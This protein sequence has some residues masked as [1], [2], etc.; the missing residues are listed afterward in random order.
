MQFFFTTYQFSAIKK[1][2]ATVF[3]SLFL[4]CQPAV[5]EKTQDSS[6]NIIETT[7]EHQ[8]ATDLITPYKD[9]LE[10]E[11]NEVL[12]ISAEEFPKEKGKPETKL[13]NLVADLSIEIAQKTYNSNIDFCLLNFGGLRTSLPKGEITRGKIFELMPF[14]NELV[15]V[16]ISKEQFE[17]LIGYLYTVGGQPISKGITLVNYIEKKSDLIDAK[18]LIKE[19]K[20]RTEKEFKILTSDYLAK[21]GDNMTFFLNPI[22]YEKV[23]IKLRDAIIQYCVEQHAQGNKLNG[24]IEGRIV[25]E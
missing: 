1:V 21:G 4:A 22:N 24:K 15:V 6:I 20:Y 14:E 10:K 11:M 18:F 8:Q 16:T 23:G 3:I 13:G 12:V 2:V 17:H 7:T 19:D 5:Y 9:S 25:Y